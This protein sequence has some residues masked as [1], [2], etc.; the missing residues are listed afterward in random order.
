M[1]ATHLGATWGNVTAARRLAGR[2]QPLLGPKK[3]P[4]PFTFGLIVQMQAAVGAIIKH[5]ISKVK[6][7]TFIEELISY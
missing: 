7:E 5:N 6:S 4:P 1:R 2:G 3:T